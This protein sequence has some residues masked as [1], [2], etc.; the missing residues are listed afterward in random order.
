MVEKAYS[1]FVY[2][3]VRLRP[4]PALAICALLFSG[5]QSV[6]FRHISSSFLWM[7]NMLMS[8]CFKIFLLGQPETKISKFM[9]IKA[10]LTRKYK[11]FIWF[12][13]T[14]YILVLW[15]GY[16]RTNTYCVF[17][18]KLLVI[19]TSTCSRRNIVKQTDVSILYTHEKKGTVLSGI[20][21][22]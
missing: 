15:L 14:D 22:S 21:T 6:S 2:T 9:Q 1:P 20:G 18:G 3:Y 5:G 4:R 16:L 8:F 10:Y 19:L 13:W 7:H 12:I 11:I 17:I